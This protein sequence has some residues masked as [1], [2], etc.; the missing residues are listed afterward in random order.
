MSLFQ[1]FTRLKSFSHM[2]V[3]V[4]VKEH[5]SRHLSF[6]FPFTFSDSPRL[7]VGRSVVKVY[8]SQLSAFQYFRSLVVIH[9][10]D[11]KLIYWVTFVTGLCFSLLSLFLISQLYADSKHAVNRGLPQRIQRT[12]IGDIIL[13]MRPVSVH[14]LPDSRQSKHSQCNV[15][16]ATLLYSQRIH[17]ILTQTIRTLASKSESENW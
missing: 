12:A 6:I 8:S 15:Q 9:L 13:Q 5:W 1:C 14:L 11:A 2:T 10:I 16:H 4:F 3:C 17:L 7:R